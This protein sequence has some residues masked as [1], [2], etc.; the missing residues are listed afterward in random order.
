MARPN[1]RYGSGVFR[2]RIGVHV[3]DARVTVELEDGNHGFRLRLHHDA[4]AV[5]ADEADPIRHPFGTCAEAVRPLAQFVGARLAEGTR[6]LRERLDAGAHCTHLYDMA[7]L[8]LAHAGRGPRR[9]QYDMAVDD[10]TDA[11]ARAEV[12]RD[13]ALV[14]A[15]LVRA[16]HVVA[17]A[18]FA[19]KPMMRG[20]HAWAQQVF[21]GEALEAAG[22]LQRAYFVAQSRRFDYDPPEANPGSADGM[23]QGSCYSY[24]RGVVERALRSRGTVRDFTHAP[25]RLLRF[26]PVARKTEHA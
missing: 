6:P 11:P 10:E 18:P 12:R 9:F 13:G 5:T 17:P 16:R 21:A 23:P 22:A 4:D 25:E 24:N 14:H 15:W 19:G 3:E 1:P 7:M 26:D 2:R 20:F 8:A